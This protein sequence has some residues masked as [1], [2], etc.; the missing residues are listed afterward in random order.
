M[1]RLL[2]DVLVTLLLNEGWAEYAVE[3]MLDGT[4]GIFH[5]DKSRI[6]KNT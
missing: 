4:D 1:C 5:V 3:W 2:H 6:C